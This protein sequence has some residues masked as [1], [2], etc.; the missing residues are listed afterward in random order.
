MLCSYRAVHMK[1][2]PDYKYRPRRKPKLVQPQKKNDMGG[3]G[4]GGGGGSEKPM[5]SPYPVRNLLP[6]HGP[7]SGTVTSASGMMLIP[8]GERLP[9]TTATAAAG[10]QPYFSP[11]HQ[12]QYSQFLYH[13]MARD[14]S[15]SN[16]GGGSGG[17]HHPEWQAMQAAVL[18]N[19]A[20]CMALW[21]FVARANGTVTGGSPPG[22]GCPYTCSRAECGGQNQGHLLH[23]RPAVPQPRRPPPAHT[24]TRPSADDSFTPSP[25]PSPPTRHGPSVFASVQASAALVTCTAATVS[26]TTVSS[27]SNSNTTASGSG[28]EAAVVR[29]IALVVHAPTAATPTASFHPQHVIWRPLP[30][31]AEPAAGTTTAATTL[32]ATPTLTATPQQQCAWPRC[33]SSSSSSSPP[34]PPP[35]PPWWLQQLQHQLI[36][37]AAAAAVASGSA[38]PVQSPPASPLSQPAT[39]GPA[40]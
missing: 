17:D 6:Q 15:G 7:P 35:P 14:L 1:D 30:V 9:A 32:A 13:Q 28:V 19:P 21:P 24:V 2:H 5:V 34:P 11:F 16:G 40:E 22:C 25:T 29:P 12:H 26:T 37:R 31:H 20:W 36:A 8:A 18:S 33:A 39:I 23:H 10:P 38:P 27:S 3:G 4:G